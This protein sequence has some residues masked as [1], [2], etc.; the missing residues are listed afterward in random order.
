[1]RKTSGI[2]ELFHILWQDCHY[3]V[4]EKT[5]FKF[6]G[7]IKEVKAQIQSFDLYFS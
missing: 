5:E 2:A 3:L 4:N 1:M 7:R 6:K